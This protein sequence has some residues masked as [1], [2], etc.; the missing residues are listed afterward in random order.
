MKVLKEAIPL[1][2]LEDCVK[3]AG[4]QGLQDKACFT[5][6][7]IRLKDFEALFPELAK[8]YQPYRARQH[9]VE[10]L[11]PRKAISTLKLLLSSHQLHLAHSMKVTG[12]T[13]LSWYSIENPMRLEVSK[14]AASGLVSFN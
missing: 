8:Y 10:P 11:T 3:V 2:L 9:L 7:Q 14:E 4:L 1:E 12:G 5:K 13:R 6:S